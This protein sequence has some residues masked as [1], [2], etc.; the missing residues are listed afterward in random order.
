MD[1]VVNDNPIKFNE[2]WTAR[3]VLQEAGFS[4]GHHL[5]LVQDDDTLM[6]IDD[7][8]VIKLSP[9]DKYVAVPPASKGMANY[10]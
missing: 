8:E 3:R 10:T 5:A 1:I 6:H 7:S 2:G 9:D 4:E